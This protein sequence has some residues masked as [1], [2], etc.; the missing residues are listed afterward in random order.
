[1]PALGVLTVAFE[2]GQE[3]T[4]S[5]HPGR[6]GSTLFPQADVSSVT[7]SAKGFER[8]DTA[9]PATVVTDAEGKARI[10]FT[11]P[12]WHRIKATVPGA[13]QEEAIRSNRL[14]VCVPAVGQSDCGALPA[15][16]QVRVPPST[17]GEEGGP[18]DGGELPNESPPPSNTPEAPNVG[19]NSSP[20][21]AAPPRPNS[22]ATQPDPLRVSAP[23]L[24][25]T[26]LRQGRLGVSWKVLDAGAGVRQWTISSQA[27]GGKG[28]PYVKRASGTTATSA[29]L[30]LPRGHAYR[31][32][33]TITDALGQTSNLTLG[34]V[35]IPGGRRG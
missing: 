29:S 10:T 31:L 9:D 34:K 7:T 33:F 5:E 4:P 27:L 25:R 28:A 2:D 15:E 26:K 30:R 24:D 20:T 23:S 12:G 22:T 13:T 14:D 21:S 3:D 1:V 19:G 16:D 32:R 11:T 8:V 17:G 6:E 35:V 18:G